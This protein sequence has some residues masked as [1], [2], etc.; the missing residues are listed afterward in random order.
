MEVSK[1]R[2]HYNGESDNRTPYLPKNLEVSFPKL[3]SFSL[4]HALPTVL[5]H[6]TLLAS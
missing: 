5:P 2:L 3:C 6:F 4:E 1:L